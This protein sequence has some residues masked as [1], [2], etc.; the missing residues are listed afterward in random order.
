MAD[1]HHR[2]VVR[3]AWQAGGAAS[4]LL[5]IIG[6]FLPL[7]PTTPF[8]LL[9]A[10]CFARGSERLHDWLL[11]HPRFGPPIDAWR[12][13]GA[14]SRKNKQLAA[15]AM[16]LAFLASV[17]MGAPG[18]AL[19]LQIVVLMAVGAFIFSRPSPPATGVA[20]RTAGGGAGDAEG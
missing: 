6:A 12:R 9:A 5:G 7:L 13:H 3:L 20:P 14:I 16:A 15:L 19:L 11:A 18:Y 2:H 8:L 4:L 17:L 10:F 1:K